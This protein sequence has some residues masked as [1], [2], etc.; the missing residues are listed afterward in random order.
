MTSTSEPSLLQNCSHFQANK[1]QRLM[2]I[3]FLGTSLRFKAPVDVTILFSSTSILGRLVGLD[4]V[5]IMI[6]SA[7]IFSFFPLLLISI[8]FDEII[9][10]VPTNLVTLFFCNKKSIPLV[11]SST[12]P[13][14]YLTALVNQDLLQYDLYPILHFHFF[15]LVFSYCSDAYSIAFEGIHPILTRTYLK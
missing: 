14:F 1:H 10:A 6:L 9:F 11:N 8:K 7:E 15:L 4:P 5:A 12:I 13:S 2:T 3:I